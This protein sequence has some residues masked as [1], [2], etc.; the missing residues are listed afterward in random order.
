MSANHS[1]I[2]SEELSFVNGT[3]EREAHPKFWIAALVQMNCEKKVA[4]K[5]DKLGIENYVAIQKE[6]RQWSDRKKVIDRIV[7]PM[8]VFIRVKQNEDSI[9]RNYSFIHKLFT[10]P[11]S[12]QVATPIPDKQI[13][14]LKFLLSNSETPVSIVSNL[15]VGDMVRITRGA[16]KGYVGLLCGLNDNHKAVAVRINGLGYACVT[17]S[18]N[19]IECIKG[20]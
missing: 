6:E 14:N 2:C 1:V 10:M 8:V 15:E 9:I 12:T 11:G 17:V 20:E 16:L 18:C 13:E 19:D 7:I 5:L 3:N 4:A